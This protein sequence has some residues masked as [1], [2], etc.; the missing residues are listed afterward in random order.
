MTWRACK[1]GKSG[2]YCVRRDNCVV[3][4]LGTI[5]DDGEFSDDAV[6]AN[7]DVITDGSCLD[8]R[9]GTNMNMIPNFHRVVIECTAE[10]FVRRS[11]AIR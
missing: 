9:A 4:D 11:I 1:T 10:G 3:C 8:D 7:L 5:L 2:D 6:L